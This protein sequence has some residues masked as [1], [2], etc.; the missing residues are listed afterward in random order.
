MTKLTFEWGI[1]PLWSPDGE[2]VFFGFDGVPWDIYS[3]PV[4]GSGPAEQLTAGAY[5]V[6][7]SITSDGKTIVFRQGG[8]GDN[9][10]IGMVRLEGEGEPEMLLETSFNEHT[11]KLS[12]DDRWLAYVS[13]ES[14]R[15]EIYVSP[16]PGSGKVQISTEGGMEPMWSR[17]GRELFYR[18][19]EKM[20]AVAI[21]AG[22]ELSPGKPTLLFEGRYDLIEGPGASN[23]DVTPDGQGF[24]MIRTPEG[25]ESLGTTQIT[26]VQNWFEELRQ[27]APTN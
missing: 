10:D 1:L 2:R 15:D 12:P 11:P 23:Y 20:M 6:P 18:N 27:L 9:L 22:P 25:P 7:T 19:G 8:A 21:S 5:R 3:K 13:N 4:D 26:L 16:F 14:G 17:D 24:V